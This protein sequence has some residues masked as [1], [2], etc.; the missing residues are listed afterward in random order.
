MTSGSNYRIKERQKE[1]DKKVKNKWADNDKVKNDGTSVYVYAN[2]LVCMLHLLPQTFFCHSHLSFRTS[3]SGEDLHFFHTFTHQQDNV[4]LLQSGNCEWEREQNEK[5]I[6]KHTKL[7][8]WKLKF[9]YK[10]S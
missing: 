2:S 1:K 9:D 4:L 3:D 6:T 5:E 10:Y 7:C 8:S